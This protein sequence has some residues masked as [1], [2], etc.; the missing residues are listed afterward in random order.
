MKRWVYNLGGLLAAALLAALDQITKTAA[1]ER[2]AGGPVVLI[3]GVFQFQYLENRGA[4]F[5]IFQNQRWL[6]LILTAAFLIFAV[7]FY[8]RIPDGKRYR[9]MR[10]I[11]VMITAGA[12]GNLIDRVFLV[13]VRDFLYFVL[14]DFP[15]FNVADIYVTVSAAL[16]IWAVLFYYK[17]EELSFLNTGRSEEKRAGHE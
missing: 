6:F 1:K 7:W 3:D 13:Y 2:L 5:G 11:C 17:D 12:V 15:I 4:A 10:V 16:M 9:L 14:I 8:I